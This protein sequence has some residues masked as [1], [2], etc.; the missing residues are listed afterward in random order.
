MYAFM[1]VYGNAKLLKPTS[2]RGLDEQSRWSAVSPRGVYVARASG[3][4][5]ISHCTSTSGDLS[6]AY[7][8]N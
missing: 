2:G 5:S 4:S 1:V 8:M 7:R 3:Y 6:D